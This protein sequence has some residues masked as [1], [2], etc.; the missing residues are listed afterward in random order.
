MKHM[1]RRARC[2]GKKNSQILAQILLKL[3]EFIQYL[4]ARVNSEVRKKNTR[5]Q[6]TQAHAR[7][8]AAQHAVETS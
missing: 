4:G 1:T 6:K 7:T 2:E 5:E 3:I 8:V